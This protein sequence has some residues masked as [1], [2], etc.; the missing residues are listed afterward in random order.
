MNERCDRRCRMPEKKEECFVCCPQESKPDTGAYE[1]AVNDARE[2]KIDTGRRRAKDFADP[3]CIDTAQIYDSCRDRDC[4][5]DSRVYLT[6]ENQELI[7]RAINV[8]LK[9]AEVI[10]V[11]TDVEIPMYN[12]K[13]RDLCVRAGKELR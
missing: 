5:A 2:E 1:A 11:F 13:K 12:L 7:E 6:A 4:V 8:K 3:V 9:K 10:W